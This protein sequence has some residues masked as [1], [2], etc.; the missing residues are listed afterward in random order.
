VASVTCGGNGRVLE[1]IFDVREKL[2]N[3]PC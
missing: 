3:T 1:K 2:K